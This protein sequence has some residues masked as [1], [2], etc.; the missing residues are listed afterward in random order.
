MASRMLLAFAA[1]I[2]PVAFFSGYAYR[3]SLDDR[4]DGA[5]MESVSVAQTA[6]AVVQGLL[7]DLD[8]TTLAAA[9]AI[10]DRPEPLSQESVG[11][12]LTGLSR[13]YPYVRQIVL[14]DP[15]GRAAAATIPGTVG[16]DFGSRPNVRAVLGGEDFVLTDLT[17]SALTGEPAIIM[18]RSVRTPGGI[19]RGVLALVFYPARL[20]DVFPGS[21]PEDANL[22]V[23]DRKGALIYSDDPL[24]PLADPRPAS[25]SASIQDALDGRIATLRG[26]KSEVDT[27]QRLGAV[28]PVPDYGWVVSLTRTTGAVEGPLQRFYRRQVFVLSMVT[29]G[30]LALALLVSRTLSRPLTR[31][32]GQARAYSIGR[33]T[34]LAPNGPPEI[35]TLAEALNT[36]AAQ[37]QQRFAEREAAE[38]R[39]AFLLDAS[40]QLAGSLDYEETLSSVARLV[41]PELADWC[42]VHVLDPGG[43]IRRTAVAHIDPAREEMLHDLRRRYP[44]LITDPHPVARVFRS[45]EAVFFPDMAE[46]NLRSYAHDDEQFSLLRQ[47]IRSYIAVPLTA[48]DVTFGVLVL[49][50]ENPGPVYDQT[51]LALAQILARRAALAVENAR[52]YHEAQDSLDGAKRALAMRDE[53]LSIASHE[54]RTPLTALKSNLQLARRRLQRGAVQEQ[55]SELVVQANAQT[56]RLAGLVSDLLDVSRLAAGR[57]SIERSPADIGPLVTRIVQTELAADPAR[58]I[59]LSLPDDI[60]PV[61]MDASRIEQ[62]L[63]NLIENARKY[64]PA[65]RPVHVRVTTGAYALM[66]AVQ[67]HGIGVPHEDHERIFERF[68]RAA[69]VDKGVSGL[70]LGLHIAREIVHAHGGTLTLESVPGSGSTFTVT[71]PLLRSGDSALDERVQAPKS[72]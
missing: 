21:L 51:D 1:L 62:V 66:I 27:H 56:D 53:F 43:Q 7:R 57:L 30:A 10:A 58:A 37:V 4:R 50:M 38:R 35:E 60:P 44:L 52:L 70:G 34:F 67:D 15:Q 72:A 16:V 32:A 28:V 45:G 33:P 71:L 19:L 47:L 17:A 54:L 5:L 42:T 61:E 31:L 36:M 18:T 23:F 26:L 2:L 3:S 13:R 68:H 24:S 6:A 39:L 20:A 48:R 40:T 29:A 41:V 11:P 49:A 69:N 22:S 55:V 63:L 25:A 59:E 12:Y 9:Q 64:S 8:G 65:D 14:I 46:E